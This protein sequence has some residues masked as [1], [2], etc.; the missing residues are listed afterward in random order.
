MNFSIC[1]PKN[2]A[3]ALEDA[4]HQTGSDGWMHDAVALQVWRGPDI[5]AI[6]VV[7]NFAGTSVDG[8]LATYSPRWCHPEAL[9]VVYGY[10]RMRC[11]IERLRIPMV[12]SNTAA[13]IA[14][15]KAGFQIDGVILSGSCNGSDA[16]VMSRSM[17]A[18][19][20]PASPAR[21]QHRPD[22]LTVED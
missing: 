6:I 18:P 15:L 13:Q 10:L 12:R 22:G 11:R 7:Q 2:Q 14:A 5:M 9:R 21:L 1:L 19:I 17:S 16:I 20:R 4:R 8:H 3:G